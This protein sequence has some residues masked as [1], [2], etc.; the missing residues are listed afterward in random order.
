MTNSNYM[1]MRHIIPLM[2]QSYNEERCSFESL[3]RLRDILNKRDI[4]DD[5]G[6]EVEDVDSTYS[7]IVFTYIG[8][9]NID[10]AAYSVVIVN[11]SLHKAHYYALKHSVTYTVLYDGKNFDFIVNGCSYGI[12]NIE[13]NNEYSANDALEAADKEL[14]VEKALGIARLEDSVADEFQ[15]KVPKAKEHEKGMRLLQK[16]FAWN[17]PLPE[18][19]ADLNEVFDCLE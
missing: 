17:G 1:V 2:V 18:G 11:H 15:Q 16:H 13:M 3:T 8:T 9:G 19:Y 14:F 7:V 5:F 12:F 4:G 10:E 6:M